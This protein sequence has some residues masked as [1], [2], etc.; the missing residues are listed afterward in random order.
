MRERFLLFTW[1]VC[2]A[3]AQI[4][5]GS[6]TGSGGSI[7]VGVRL[8]VNPAEIQQPQE[9]QQTGP[10]GTVE[11]SVTNAA[12]GEFLKRV[13]IMLM[14]AQGGP[15]RSPYSSS[16][17][18]TGQFSMANIAPGMY[19][20]M[21]ERNGFVRVEYG[22]RAAGRTGSVLT[23]APGQA[24]KQVSLRM[25]PHAVIAGR[26]LD[27]DG[28]P[29]AYVQVQ[30]LAQRYLQGRRQLAPSGGGST[31]DLGEYRIFGLTAGKY[32]ISATH[33]AQMF[34]GAVDRTAS[35]GAG[36]Q[37]EGYAPTYYP[38]ATDA[39]AAVPVQVAVGQPLNNIDIKLRRVPTVR[40]RGKVAGPVR[41]GRTMVMLLPDSD[42]AISFGGPR[43]LASTQGPDGAFEI[44]GVTPGAYHLFAQQ[45]DGSG[46]YT[47]RLPITVG[48]ATIENIELVVKPGM[49]VSG[50]VRIEGD[51]QINPSQ[52]TV[53]LQ[54]KAQGPF[55]NSG[56]GRVNADGSFTILNVS[57]NLY[58]VSANV[59]TQ[60]VYLKSIL[61][62]NQEVPQ[63]EL[64]VGD[65]SAPALTVV[66]SAAAGQISGQV[67][68]AKPAD[69]QGATVVLVPS[70]DK[71]ERMEMYKM[72]TSDQTGRFSL[73][74]IPPGEYTVYAWDSVE[75]GSWQDPE[76]LARFESKGKKITLK[77]S[78]SATVEA[79][80]IKVDEAQN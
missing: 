59:P 79:E 4:V 50:R 76:F 26:V 38:A 25:Q 43:N 19:R 62:E 68:A 11:G 24:L 13:T 1:T 8:P 65:G 53:M 21:A 64:N 48:N 49:E 35:S 34:P 17:D 58:R 77:E 78:E 44:R 55:A 28:E 37:E 73:K 51:A 12:T 29:L 23:I 47:A 74:S 45:S 67:A 39:S 6:G 16:T 42:G 57:P 5:G 22:A 27:E 2:C 30:A 46:Q 40:V 7:G 41:Q 60:G 14:P 66:L 20:L 54:P 32:Y 72:T 15:N 70:A 18:A 75:P 61:V 9:P 63:R 52:V 31:N 33:R 71:R 56:T 80:L 36:A 3:S 10:P 69:A